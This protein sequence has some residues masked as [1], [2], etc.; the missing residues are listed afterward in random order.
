MQLGYCCISYGT[1]L[2]VFTL[3]LDCAELAIRK[4]A[5]STVVGDGGSPKPPSKQV[6]KTLSNVLIGML[7]SSFFRDEDRM[8]VSMNELFF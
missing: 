2:H 1:A 5:I 4:R 8:L 6:K 7:W 3:H